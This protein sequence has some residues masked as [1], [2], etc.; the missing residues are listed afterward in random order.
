[1]IID[2]DSYLIKPS[3]LLLLSHL[4]WREEYYLGN[5]VGDFKGRFAHG[6]S[7]VVF[8]RPAVQKLLS[9]PDILA[10]ANMLALSETWGDKLVA[11]TFQKVGVYLDERYS[12]HFNGER[13]RITRIYPDKFCSPLVSFHGV[14][15]QDEMRKISGALG[16]LRNPMLWGHLWP[17]FGLPDISSLDD[18]YYHV[19]HDHV[20]R[21]DE[22]SMH[23][24][25]LDTP[26]ECRAKCLGRYGS[27]CVAWTWDSRGGCHMAPWM[28]IGEKPGGLISGINVPKVK[29]LARHC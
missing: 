22:G 17:L 11:T 14:S 29:G 21:G 26:E 10:E 16:R 13:P 18:G 3:L 19:D 20:G 5:A 9:R 7:G 27:W 24:D 23:V 8:S 28:V 4:D 2:D 15:D 1:M 6:G 25:G 12:H